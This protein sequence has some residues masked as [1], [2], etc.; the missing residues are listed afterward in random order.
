[1]IAHLPESFIADLVSRT[2]IIELI[3]S[4]VPLIKRG[5]NHVACCPF[6][7]E[8]SPS[9]TV[10][11]DKQFYYCFGCGASGNVIS[12]LRNHDRMDFIEAITYLANQI[13]IELPNQSSSNPTKDRQ[14]AYDLLSQ[15]AK[16]YQEELRQS[17]MAIDYLKSRG[18][19]GQIAKQFGIGYAPNEWDYLKK[20][21]GDGAKSLLIDTGVLI[22]KDKTKS[23]D[24]FR[25]RV[26][27]P[28]RNLRGQV[29]G[30]G[31]RS[32]N[33]DMPKYLNSPET[34]LFHKSSELYGFYEA[35]KANPEF[36]YI[37]VVEGYMDVVS[38][39]QHGITQA[40]ATLGT[41][42][43]PKHLQ[44]ILLYS[45]TIVFCFDGDTAGQQAAWKALT[46]SLAM[47]RDGV[48]IRFLFLPAKEDPDSLVRQIGKEE[49]IKR[50][51]G[52]TSL[53]NFLFAKLRQ[54]I[55]MHSTAGK[56]HFAHEATQLL[57]QIPDG[58][59]QK[60]LFE[61]LAKM[62][63]VDKASL[64]YLPPSSSQKSHRK[65][66]SAADL[67]TALLL[68]QPNLV[69]SIHAVEDLNPLLA[70]PMP[71]ISTL[72]ELIKVLKLEPGLTTGQLL[73][74]D[75]PSLDHPWDQQRIAKLAAYPLHVPEGGI[76]AEFIGSI[77][78]LIR[79][80]QEYIAHKLIEKAKIT[81]LTSEE[82][83]RLQAIINHKR[84]I[85]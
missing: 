32:L 30:F 48:D 45:P 68:Q 17:P 53:G 59:Y 60:L 18:L 11:R 47:L 31:G 85:D 28:I 50:L 38:L 56:A 21:L 81:E 67:A 71:G 34:Y 82:K 57:K 4:R 15:I 24:F 62:L 22:E 77:H 13:G 29:V 49:F 40:V 74:R 7:Q 35:K 26:I 16:Y 51:N 72:I 83:Q 54:E 10:N 69:L 76:Q 55:D 84:T 44:K 8:K 39:A 25:H 33:N 37:V 61:Q 9:F 5:K 75:A 27:F 3:Q 1:M 6:H 58:I 36:K 42:I 20:R 73:A 79:Q 70:L 78:H 12:F 63:Q 66:L 80:H 52:A 46:I 14:P 41:A 65:S 19:T 43:N 23:Y 2:D 64:G